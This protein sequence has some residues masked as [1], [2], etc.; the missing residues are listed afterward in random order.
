MLAGDSALDQ[1]WMSRKWKDLQ[2]NL[3]LHCYCDGALFLCIFNLLPVTLVAR[4]FLADPNENDQSSVEAEGADQGN[5]NDWRVEHL[6]IKGE[7]EPVRDVADRVEAGAAEGGADMQ[8]A[9]D[10]IPWE[11]A[12]GWAVLGTHLSV[13]D[14]VKSE[15]EHRMLATPPEAM[16]AQNEVVRWN[17]TGLEGV[18]VVGCFGRSNHLEN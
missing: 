11:A 7:D 1:P 18:V 9:L 6:V 17:D 3:C 14:P 5:K 15:K 4:S 8:V 16:D 13:A 2:S 12:G 10:D